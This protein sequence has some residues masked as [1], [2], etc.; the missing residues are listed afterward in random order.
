[1]EFLELCETLAATVPYLVQGGP[2]HWGLSKISMGV[3]LNGLPLLV[4]HHHGSFPKG[5]CCAV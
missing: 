4:M 1:M 5:N 2:G 3:V